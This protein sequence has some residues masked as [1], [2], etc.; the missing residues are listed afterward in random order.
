[1]PQNPKPAKSKEAKP[2]VARKPPKGD[3]ARVRNLEKRLAEAQEQ[4]TATS[5]ILAVISSSPTDLEPVFDTIAEHAVRLCDAAFGAVVRFDGEWINIAALSG[6]RPDEREAVLRYFPIRPTPGGP[7]L[8]R[9]MQTGAAVHIPDVQVD[10]GWRAGS[11]GPHFSTVEGFRTFLAVPLMREGQ[12]LGAVN[13]WRREVSPFSEQH[14]ALLKT[15]ADQAVIAI[16]NVRLFNETKEALDRQTATSEILGV[17]SSSPTDVQPTFEAIARAASILCEA[18]FGSLFPFDG[19]LIHLGA[20]YGR[21]PEETDAALRAFPQRP[22]R[23]SVTSRAILA[24][25]VVQIADVGADPE[26]HDA[27]RIFRT[28]LAVPMMRDGRSAGAITVARRVVR[29]FTDKQIALLK[30]FADQAVIAIQNV[31]LFNETKEALERQTATSEILR[32]IASSP[33]DLQPVLNAVAE[34]AARLCGANDAVIF[35]VDGDVRRQV[36][37]FGSIPVAVAPEVRLGR[38]SVTS[39]AI[40]ERRTVHIHDLLEEMARPDFEPPDL[41]RDITFRTILATPLLREDTAIGAITI[42]RTE[43]HPFTDKQ[44]ALL[45]TFADQAVIAIE[46]VRLFTELQTSNREL[47]TALDTQTATSDILRVISRTQTDVQPVFDA[48]LTSAVRLLRAYV[49]YITRVV[50]NQS[51]LVAIKAPN[52]AS[53]AGMRASYPQSLQSDS[54][55]AQAIRDR[56]PL[57]IAD[58]EIDSRI[59]ERTRV[60]ARLHGYRSWLSVPLLRHAD[61]VGTILIARREPGGFTDEEIALLKTFADQAVIAIE[62]VR[63]FTELQTRTA[64]LTRSVDQLTALGEVGRAVSSTLDL[65]TVLTTIV[66][67]AVQLSGLDGGVVFEYDEAAEEFIQRVATETGGT[68]AEVRRATRFRKGEGVLGRTAITLEP[69]QVPDITIPG[70]YESRLRGN[71]IESGIRSIL[72]VP[73]VREDRLIGCLAVTRKP[74]RRVRRRDDRAAAD[75]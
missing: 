29:P 56:A 3:G 22:S 37:H 10:P 67:R 31:R 72:A 9:V 62:N 11:A 38:G 19:E 74:S 36:A 5:E 40:R 33:T 1:M 71:L 27:L 32:V 69:V 13:V 45:Q 60:I 16:E 12:C 35:S 43:M 20:H 65:E 57:N 6:L 55:T 42:R 28:A 39:R 30:T 68:L 15:F 23:S 48:I 41:Q 8:S 63:L 18:D 25:D 7:G 50:G 52:E 21:T 4:Q 26:I 66:S 24:G 14:I 75:L 53:E 34:R 59:S 44:I 49:G 73:M 61:P 64:A 51:E 70:A 2:P 17:I 46:N 54:V 47:T 58:Y